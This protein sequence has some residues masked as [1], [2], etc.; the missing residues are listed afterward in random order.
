[1]SFFNLSNFSEQLKLPVIGA[2]EKQL[3]DAASTLNFSLPNPK[4]ILTE[5]L[6]KLAG[7]GLAG[8]FK[9]LSPNISILSNNGD[10]T[11]VNKV[12]G[13]P[14][15]KI[16][17]YPQQGVPSNLPDSENNSENF[18]VSLTQV[19][20]ID[21]IYNNVVFDITPTI[22]EGRSASYD[23]AQIL[24]HPGEILKYRSTSA[25]TWN[26]TA[27]FMSRSPEEASKNLTYINLLR[28]WVMPF[29]GVG[30]EQKLNQYLGAP[31]PILLLRGYGKNLIGE[32][33]CIL[34]SYSWNW[35]NEI[36]YIPTLDLTPFP[37]LVSVTLNLKESFSPAE[38]SSFDLSS[39]YSGDISE[40][41]RLRLNYTQQPN[42]AGQVTAPSRVD[43]T[44]PMQTTAA[45]AATSTSQ[46]TVGLGQTFDNTS[47]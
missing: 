42:T 39:Y 34:E 40:A 5:G 36:D 25:R 15:A 28:S 29:Y 21:D 38:Y 17:E 8:K 23:S 46:G 2:V 7:S 10:F 16:G 9:S 33:K 43:T 31:P 13:N 37:V 22:S 47:A 4:T 19:P 20:I 18:K 27:T 32:T 6:S 35:E 30:T 44:E 24:H 41:F 12:T 1:M 11:A 14:I 3:T 26:I 45:A